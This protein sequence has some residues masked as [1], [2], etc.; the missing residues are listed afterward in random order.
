MATTKVATAAGTLEKVLD[1]VS[2]THENGR[3]PAERLQNLVFVTSEVAPWSKTGGLGDV[4]GSL[5]PVL[6]ARGHRVMV[7]AP[8][9]GCYEDAIDTGVEVT[10]WLSGAHHT[11]RFFHCQRGNVD[12]I[13]VDHPGAYLRAGNPYGDDM[14]TFGDNQF[15]FTLLSMAALEAPLVVPT[16][17]D[18]LPYGDDIMFVANDWQ[19]ALVPTLLATKYRPHGCYWQARTLLIIHNL[20]RGVVAAV[21]E[22]SRRAVAAG[23]PH[24]R[25]EPARAEP[26]RAEPARATR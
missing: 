13:F 24:A 6:A 15:R 8:R 21:A 9:Y 23:S 26:A 17:K 12:W 18:G 4:C 22:R 5:P 11:V 20:V 10:I 14:G 7:V 19:A 1:R 2:S 3:C 25:A 16:G